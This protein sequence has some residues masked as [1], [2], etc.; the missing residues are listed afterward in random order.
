MLNPLLPTW[1]TPKNYKLQAGLV[2]LHVHLG[3]ESAYERLILPLCVRL[4]NKLLSL[5]KK[6][7]KGNPI[8]TG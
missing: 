8:N 6:P 7:E 2:P 4:S 1:D 5:K 3:V